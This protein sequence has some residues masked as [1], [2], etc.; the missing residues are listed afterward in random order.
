[1]HKTQ[2]FN[3]VARVIKNSIEF[4]AHNSFSTLEPEYELALADKVD[5]MLG[6]MFTPNKV[7]AHYNLPLDSQKEDDIIE[8]CKKEDNY[9]YNKTLISRL[10][11]TVDIDVL[12]QDICIDVIDGNGSRMPSEGLNN[13]INETGIIILPMFNKPQRTHKRKKSDGTVVT[14]VTKDADAWSDEI[15]N[16][17]HNLYYI[18]TD[19]LKG[20]RI[21]NMFIGLGGTGKSYLKVGYTPVLNDPLNAVMIFDDDIIKEDDKKNKLLYFGNVQL[22]SPDEIEE[23]FLTCYNRACKEKIDILFA[24]EMLGTERLSSAD[25]S[26]YNKLFVPKAE[27]GFCTP[28]LTLVPTY[29]HNRTN[30]LS[31]FSS[32][33]KKLIEQYKQKSFKL[34]G[35]KGI[36]TEDLTDSPKEIALVHIDGLGRLAFPI[37]ADYLD[38][39]Y[40]N[41][42]ITKLKASFIICP[43]Y[44]F[45]TSSF[46]QLVSSGSAYGVRCI[47]GNSCSAISEVQEPP[48]YPCL[49]STPIISE[50]AQKVRIHPEC[51]GECRKLCLFKIDIPLD[52]GGDKMH[53]DIN[54]EYTHLFE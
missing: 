42:L 30:V 32:S 3:L 20:F 33:G 51:G 37:C 29:W 52:C 22:L 16:A 1:M 18:K 17:M 50:D 7:Y 31:I 6:S 25:E 36:C 27:N 54:I 19:D 15:N 23:N 48:D 40:R 10:D 12:K 9:Y 28:F 49:V 14:L 4:S 53:E 24:P 46:E 35:K 11:S 34:K 38:E 45:G 13:N 41:I 47:W 39:E 2:F 21:K 44:S 8:Q 5:A 26:G 43:S